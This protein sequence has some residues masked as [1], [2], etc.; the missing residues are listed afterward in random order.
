[1]IVLDLLRVL[2]EPFKKIIRPMGKGW[3]SKYDA[4]LSYWKSRH[5]I[6]GGV[7]KNS[8]YKR[9]MLSI[10][11]EQDD[12]F[13][14]GKVVADFGC[15][16]RGSL[17]WATSA[18]LRI[19]I[20]VLADQ[21]ADAFAED[22][23]SHGMIYLK[24]TEKTIPLPPNFID[25]MFTVNAMDHVDSF[26]TICREVIRVIKTGGIFV[27]SFNL[28]EPATATEPQKLNVKRIEEDLLYAFDPQ[29][30]RVTRRGSKGDPYQPFYDDDLSYGEGDTGFLWVRAI[31][32]PSSHRKLSRSER[33][34]RNG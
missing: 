14:E 24:S 8:H 13:L 30:Y 7:F 29:S 4:E 2:P 10:A 16:P 23:L 33:M 20:D 25:V 22:I 1:M 15:G 18:S 34:V 17:V 32:K 26:S 28:E 31:K 27:G 11:E 6:D 12:G 9:I 21:Y 19:G 5:R 3:V